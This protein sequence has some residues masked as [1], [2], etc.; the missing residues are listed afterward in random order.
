MHPFTLHVVRHGESEWNRKGLVQGQSPEAGGLTERGVLEAV[1]AGARL[2]A[3]GAGPG[4]IVSSDLQRAL[5]TARIIGTELDRPIRVDPSFREQRYGVL[6]GHR[7]D[8]VIDGESVRDSIDALWSDLSRS[9]EGGESVAEMGDRVLQAVLRLGPDA[10]AIV[11]CH[12][13]PVRTLLERARSREIVPG[14]RG[15]VA[16]GS[17]ATFTVSRGDTKAALAMVDRG[18]RPTER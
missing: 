13:G 5:E 17:I 11:V 2:R 6:E 4:E 10:E 9:P 18:L 3:L 12:G 15:E 14:L 7:L 1:D 16:N 8:E